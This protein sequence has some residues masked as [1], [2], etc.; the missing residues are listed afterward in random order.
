MPKMPKIDS[1]NPDAPLDF[2]ERLQPQQRQLT[3]KEQKVIDALEKSRPGLGDVAKANILNPDS[4][5]AIKIAQMPEEEIT[6]R[7]SFAANSFSYHRI[8]H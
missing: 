1:I 3:G 6:V 2:W 8:G 5:W 4:D 7:T